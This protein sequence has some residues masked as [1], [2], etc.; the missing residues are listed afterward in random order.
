L[1]NPKGKIVYV[2]SRSSASQHLGHSLADFLGR[3]FIE[4]ENE[5]QFS[6]IFAEKNEI[7]K[8][9][10]AFDQING[11]KFIEFGSKFQSFRY[12]RKK[13]LGV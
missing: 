9:G 12:R 13:L 6:H 7:G 3:S 4:G 5:I 10:R 8:L 2:L 11:F 1:T